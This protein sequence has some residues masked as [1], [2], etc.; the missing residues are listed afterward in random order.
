MRIVL[1]TRGSQLALTQSGHVADALRA[2]GH[3]VE[4]RTIKTTG[5][6][7]TGSLVAQGGTGVFA[8]ALRDALL[9]G[10]VDIA[11]HSFKDLPTAPTQGLVVAAIPP[12][13]DWHDVL[14]A[15]DRLSLKR[16]PQGARVGTG[17]PRRSAQ[18]RALRPD[19]TLVDIRG[20]VGTR[21]ARATGPDADLDAV[22][23][24]AAGLARLGLSAAVTDVLDALL[25]APAQGALAVECREDAADIIEALTALDDPDT[26]FAATAERA[27]LAELGAG[28]AAPIGALCFRRGGR[29]GLSVKVLSADGTRVAGRTLEG[30]LAD[31]PEEFGRRA[32]RSLLSSGAADL[33]PLAATRPSRLDDFHDDRTLWAP[34]TSTDLVGR[35]ILLPRE[36]GPLAQSLRDAGADVTCV[37]LTETVAEVFPRLPRDANWVVFTSPTAVR[38]LL[39]QGFDLAALGRSGVAAVGS[40]TKRALDAHG[41]RVS[42]CPGSSASAADLAA[43]FPSGSGRVLIPG[44]GLAKPDLA[45]ALRAK[46]WTVRSVA[47][48][49]TKPLDAAP[50]ALAEAWARGDFDAVVLTAGSVADGVRTLLGTPPAHTKVVA[51]GR[52]SATAAAECGLTVDAVAATQDGPGLVAAL[53]AAWACDPGGESSAPATQ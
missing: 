39:D 30:T 3:D 46:G 51:F 44:S 53:V 42:L 24:A 38:V 12:R 17:S 47:T 32:A 41:V 1:G 6:V 48:Y 43:L 5:D 7:I 50:P 14:C 34:S 27:V 18:L 29:V 4:L 31:D 15:R 19:L 23:L 11:V 40:A 26:R 16:L 36:D 21:L 25:P 52:P 8:A 2:L 49:T 20:N 35:R 9:R 37:P 28:C 33:T 45:D 22:V 13:A 10:E